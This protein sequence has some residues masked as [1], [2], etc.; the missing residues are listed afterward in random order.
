W[1][2]FRTVIAVGGTNMAEQRSE[3]RAGVDIVV[4]TPGSFLDHLQQ[5]NTSLSRISFIV[6]DEAD[7]MLDMGFE[8]Q[9]REV[10]RNLPAKHQTLMFT[11]TLTVEIEALVQEYLT[12]PVQ[13]IVGRARR[14]RSLR[15]KIVP[16]TPR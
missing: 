9:I 2:F 7:S 13:V 4:A 8:P 15:R 12:D 10:M 5:G 6:L 14:V 3:L 11:E 16:N 1:E